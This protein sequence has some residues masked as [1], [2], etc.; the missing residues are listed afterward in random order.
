MRVFISI[1]HGNKSRGVHNPYFI[2]VEDV[3]TSRFK[4]CLV[5]TGQ[6]A[7][8]NTNINWFA[9][10]GSQSGVYHG[11]ESFSLFTTGVQCRSGTF[12]QVGNLDSA[13]LLLFFLLL[14]LHLLLYLL[15]TPRNTIKTLWKQ[16]VW[17]NNVLVTL[18]ISNETDVIFLGL[19]F[20]I[21]SPKK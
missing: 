12:P 18:A 21:G 2:W 11:V 19:R 14:L 16:D 4:A 17:N 6:D 7:V 20:Y 8:Q 13:Y 5:K 15:F 1:D 10:Q 9:F 3:T